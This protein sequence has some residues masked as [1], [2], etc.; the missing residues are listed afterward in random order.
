[1]QVVEDLYWIS[2]LSCT[3]VTCLKR[4]FF[5][6]WFKYSISNQKL[7]IIHYCNISPSVRVRTVAV[8]I[9]VTGVHNYPDV[10]CGHVFRAFQRIME[11][12]KS[13]HPTNCA[14]ILIPAPLF[15]IL[16]TDSN[17][18]STLYSVAII[19]HYL[20]DRSPS[21]TSSASRRHKKSRSFC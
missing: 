19:L 11:S 10:R 18:W 13:P 1:M 14:R 20:A 3:Q 16:G 17:N 12:W 21:A 8:L 9:S 2:C 15:E 5:W 7:Q 6:G 4:H